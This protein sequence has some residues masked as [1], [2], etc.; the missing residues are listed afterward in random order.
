MKKISLFSILFLAIL[1]QKCAVSKNKLNAE[2]GAYPIIK[3]SDSICYSRGIT[4]KNNYIY[5]A[6]SNGKI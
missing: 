3:Y 2:T 5:T 6:N 4:V 1:F